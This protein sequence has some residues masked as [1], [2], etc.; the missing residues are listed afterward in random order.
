[1]AGDLKIQ[2]LTPS[3]WADFEALFGPKGACAGCWCQF[4]RVP[5]RQWE[6]DKGDGNRAA[7]HELVA[8]GRKPG[9]LAY[10]DREAIGWVSIA[11][12]VEFVSLQNSRLFRKLVDDGSSRTWSVS[13]LFVRKDHRRT[14]VSVALLRAAVAFAKRQRAGF[15]E[16][17]PQEPSQDAMADAFAWNGIAS[18]YRAAGFEEVARPSPTRPVMRVAL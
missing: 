17:Y 8:A 4:W 7:M 13:C 3:R 5:R 15:V 9:L 1:V 6:A 18:A 14:G 16:G 11:P 2:A 10:R 12:R